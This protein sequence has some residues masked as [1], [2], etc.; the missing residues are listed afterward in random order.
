M[1]LGVVE[2]INEINSGSPKSIIGE[3]DFKKMQ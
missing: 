2:T 3:R 1:I